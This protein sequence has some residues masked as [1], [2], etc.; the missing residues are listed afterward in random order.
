MEEE[1]EEEEEEDVPVFVCAG[2]GHEVH[3]NHKWVGGWVGGW[4]G[5]SIHSRDISGWMGGWVGGW[6]VYR[7]LSA[8]AWAIRFMSMTTSLASTL[9]A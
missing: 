7:S 9:R 3:I 5:R 6:E 1:E 2:L 8:R 4:V